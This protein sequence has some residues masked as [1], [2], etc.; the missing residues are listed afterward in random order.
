MQFTYHEDASKDIIKINGI[1][2]RHI[3]KARRHDFKKHLFFRNMIDENIYE[4]EIIDLN[5]KD[6]ILKLLESINKPIKP[7]KELHIGWC[8]IDLKNIEKILSSLNEIGVTKI[9]F[10][11]CQYSQN[12]IKINYKKLDT[13]LINSSEQCGRSNKIVFDEIDSLQLFRNNN[14][15]CFMF[16]FS[17]NNIKDNIDDL[18]TIVVGPEGGFSKDEIGLFDLSKLIGIKSD[19]ILRSETAALTVASQIIL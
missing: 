11:R 2:H 5:K 13:I 15:D 1:L 10:I 18:R 3:F 14:P 4:Y 12:N 17:N 6:A 7:K 16:N 8:V 9:T 19:L